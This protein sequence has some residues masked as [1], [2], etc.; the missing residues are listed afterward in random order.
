MLFI[1]SLRVILSVSANAIQKRLLLDGNRVTQTWIL[2]YAFMLPISIIAAL[3]NYSNGGLPFWRDI[4]IGGFLDAIGNLAMVAALR[5]TDI[6]IFGPLNAIRP[7]IALLSGWIFLAEA[8][9]AAGLAGIAITI[10][11]A[12][13]LFGG[14]S[15]SEKLPRRE[16]LKLLIL[17]A[18]GI[19]LGAFGAVFLKRAALTT[20]AQMTVAAHDITTI[21]P[22]PI[23]K[24]YDQR[25][26]ELEARVQALEHPN[27][28]PV[29]TP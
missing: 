28:T 13:I 23:P 19:S 2:T 26:I 20:S 25:F 1:I 9:T 24:S 3:F 27:S 8:P 21:P 12:F 6:S 14:D 15:H 18:A 10:V 5:G 11:G 29:I 7:I 22:K 16:L 17:R 4:L